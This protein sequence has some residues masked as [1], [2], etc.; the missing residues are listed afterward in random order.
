MPGFTQFTALILLGTVVIT[1][2]GLM[3]M[4]L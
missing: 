2:F 3:S 4:A 1:A